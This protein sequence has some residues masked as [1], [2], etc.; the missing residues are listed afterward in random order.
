L[1][2]VSDLLLHLLFE[3]VEICDFY[4]TLSLLRVMTDVFVDL[5]DLVVDMC[6]DLL[7]QFSPRLLLMCSEALFELVLLFLQF[8]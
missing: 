3:L 2:A 4:V 1:F 8:V 7:H 5:G 6:Q